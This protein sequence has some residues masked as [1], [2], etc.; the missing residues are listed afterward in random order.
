AERDM[1]AILTI[2]PTSCVE[3]DVYASNLK[4]L[5]RVRYYFT[6]ETIIQLADAMSAAGQPYSVAKFQV[7]PDLAPEQKSAVLALRARFKAAIGDVPEYE[8]YT[9]Q[10]GAPKDPHD[11]DQ[12]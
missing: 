4:D 10:N 7:G 1:P 9:D 2:P 11:P 3:F 8:E 6:V 5:K 12:W